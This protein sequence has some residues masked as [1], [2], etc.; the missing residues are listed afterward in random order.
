MNEPKT[1]PMSVR[2]DDRVRQPQ[3][4]E[5]QL[6]L[7]LPQP[8]ESFVEEVMQQVRAV[9]LPVLQ[10]SLSSRKREQSLGRWLRRW[11]R[12][13]VLAGGAILGAI[14]LLGFVFGVWAAVAAG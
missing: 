14:Q 9:P 10:G 7:G 3:R 11:L 5:Q 12:W 4:W 2:I 13:L 8:P 1:D 6:D